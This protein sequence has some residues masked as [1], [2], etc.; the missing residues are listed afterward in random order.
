M[1]DPSEVCSVLRVVHCWCSFR[2]KQEHGIF[3]YRVKQEHIKIPTYKSCTDEYSSHLEVT[4]FI[5][6]HIG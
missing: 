4:K 3:D 1:N 6:V 2:A 5:S